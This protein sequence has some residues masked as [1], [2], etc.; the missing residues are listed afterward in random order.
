MRNY[1][2][3]KIQTTADIVLYSLNNLITTGMP[4][5]VAYFID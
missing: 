1:E 5:K 2:G 3:N 4:G